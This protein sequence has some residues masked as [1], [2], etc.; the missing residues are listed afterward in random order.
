MQ[1]WLGQAIQGLLRL[2]HHQGHQGGLR[3]EEAGVMGLLVIGH[4]S[5]DTLVGDKMLRLDS[6]PCLRLAASQGAAAR[7]GIAG[8]RLLLHP[9]QRTTLPATLYL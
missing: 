7:M 8:T 4:P 2:A 5:M 6:V 1:C 9:R 3:L